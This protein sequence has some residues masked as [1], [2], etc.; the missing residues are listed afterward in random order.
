MRPRFLMT[1]PDYY[2]RLTAKDPWTGHSERVDPARAR[3]QW[4]Q[5]AD[6]IR[7]AG[8]EVELLEP[9]PDFPSLVFTGS[10]ALVYAPGKAI[11]L[12]NDGPRGG[13]DPAVFLSW[14]GSRG[15]AAGALPP[16]YS[17]DGLNIVHAGRKI[18]LVG[19]GPGGMGEAE[20]YLA[21]F[22]RLTA[23]IEV[24]GVP[25]AGTP[26]LPLGAGLGNLGGRAWLVYPPV[27][28]ALEG[29]PARG[30]FLGRPVIEIKEG[31]ACCLACNMLV[32]GETIITGAISAPLQEGIRA[33]GF[34]LECLDLSEFRKAGAGASSL[35]LPLFAAW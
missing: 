7:E 24:L 32:V 12:R 15:F 5:L 4:A 10:A 33:F 28:K 26:P 20:R 11:I 6:C 19:L 29:T 1:P 35:A 27:L 9:R 22:L 16:G 23:G 21:R 34:R 17:I 30:F 8:G 18:T 3:K 13:H 31:D 14:F 2:G 25:L